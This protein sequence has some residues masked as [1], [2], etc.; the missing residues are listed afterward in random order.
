MY[1]AIASCSFG[2]LP[3]RS[4][5]RLGFLELVKLVTKGLIITGYHMSGHSW[6]LILLFFFTGGVP[7]EIRKMGGGGSIE[8]TDKPSWFDNLFR[9]FRDSYT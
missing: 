7:R 6:L 1:L 8:S 3:H 4:L 5:G 2:V 9:S